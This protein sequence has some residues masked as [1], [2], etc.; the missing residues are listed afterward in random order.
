M[1]DKD[2]KGELKSDTNRDKLRDLIAE[3]LGDTYA[4]TRVWSAWSYNTMT[5]D[6]F[7]PAWEDEEILYGIADAILKA[8]PT[9]K[10]ESKS[11]QK[12]KAIQ[13]RGKPPKEDKRE[14]WISV[15]KNDLVMAIS[16]AIAMSSVIGDE[17]F[18]Q[19][20]KSLRSKYFPDKFPSPPK[21]QTE[22]ECKNPRCFSGV[23]VGVGIN[24][25][26]TPCPDCQTEKE[27]HKSKEDGIYR[28]GGEKGVE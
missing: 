5:E 16:D 28:H 11:V 20:A 24:Q 10:E 7:K 8:R 1:S 2:S 9:P 21:A 27:V 22:K 13:M 17:N 18:N 15:E 26:A 4:C 14:E 23:L 19:N 6:D 12:R 3:G 25:K